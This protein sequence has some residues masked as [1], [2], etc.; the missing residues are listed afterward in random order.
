[1]PGLLVIILFGFLAI[2]G[3]LS[4]GAFRQQTA[5]LLGTKNVRP[6]GAT[7]YRTTFTNAMN[8]LAIDS[9]DRGCPGCATG[10]GANIVIT[11]QPK[12]GRVQ[13]V[14]TDIKPEPGYPG[15]KSVDLMYT[16]R[17]TTEEPDEFV[18]QVW[19]SRTDFVEK[20]V[21]VQIR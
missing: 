20:R 3:A 16:S 1:M 9:V 4:Q 17:K 11:K 5:T 8:G 19:T 21:V 2:L 12:A 18:Y 15:R 6:D 10:G 7:E 14:P 13:L